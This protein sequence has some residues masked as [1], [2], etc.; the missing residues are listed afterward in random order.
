MLIA[1]DYDLTYTA[2]KAMWHDILHVIRK[3]GH[4]VII[5]TM[6]DKELDWHDDF[7]YLDHNH[8]IKTVFCNGQSKKEVMDSLG[9]SVAIWVDD[10]PEGI[11]LGS[12]F[13]K[14]ELHKWRRVQ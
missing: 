12:S 8:E 6:R 1:L 2:D 5:V 3:F 14:E 10:S 11:H 9:Y 13:S 7:K 4:E